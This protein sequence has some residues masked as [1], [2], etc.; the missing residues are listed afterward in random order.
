MM[1]ENS[2]WVVRQGKRNLKI[3][4]FMKKKIM[5]YDKNSKLA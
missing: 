5:T 2:E 1:S 3:Q 4:D